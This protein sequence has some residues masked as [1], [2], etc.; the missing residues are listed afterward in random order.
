MFCCVLSNV[1]TQSIKINSI[2]NTDI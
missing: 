1:F 2:Y